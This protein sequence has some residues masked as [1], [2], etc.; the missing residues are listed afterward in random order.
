MSARV[1]VAL[2]AAVAIAG[3][4]A[5]TD[6]GRLAAVGS[7]V[8]PLP[9][10]RPGTGGEIVL[11]P[12]GRFTMGDANGRGDETPHPVSVRSFYLDRYPVTQELYEKV[13]GVNPS[14]R[15]DPMNPVE[16][17]QWTDAVRFC[18]RCS[19]MDGLTPCYDLSTWACNFDADGYRLP[20]EAEW[21]CACRA[22]STGQYSCGDDERELPRYAWFKPHSQGKPQPVGQ[23]LPNHWGLADMHG[24]VWQWCNDWYGE[25]SYKDSPQDNPHGPATGTMRVLR[26]GA[27]DCTADKC[28]SAYRHKEFPVY[29]DAC[30]GADS[31]GFRRARKAGAGGQTLPVAVAP[32]VPPVVDPGKNAEKPATVVAPGRET[33]TIDLASLKGTIVFV[34]DRSGTLKIWTMRASGKD[35]RQLTHGTEP[36][37]DP[38]FS[39]DGRQ[40][41]YTTLRGGFPEIWLMSRDGSGPKLVTKGSQAS[42]A[43]DGKSLVFI[44]DNQTYVRDL[45]T[46]AEKRVTPPE[47]ERCG[48]PAFSPDGR[49]VAVASRHLGS[50]GIFILSLDGKES[51]QLQTEEAC[52][53]PQ[54]SKDGKRVLCQ[55]VQGHIHEVGVD[56]K[57]WEQLTF[58]AD[59]QH[60]AR[61]SPDGT[62]I[63]FCRAPAPEGPWQICLKRRDADEDEFVQLTREGSNLLPDWHSAE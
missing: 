18:N 21:E 7:D 59:V 17:T 58:G 37:A 12:A 13:L 36:D 28:R 4:C 9:V 61:Y 57:N 42:W 1:L 24:N 51:R 40:V 16:R 46:G 23:K 55:T 31:Y 32:K 43:P 20:T 29:S 22:G 56:G 10:L 62:M 14:K 44:R 50:I 6:A 2:A 25:N 11:L 8:E 48:V 3:G 47:W 33:G 53:T 63:L 38:R 52:C 35:A 60:D 41:S 39:P 19:E 27:W 30:F 15:K 34:S 26:G 54:W 49:H 5:R 45:A